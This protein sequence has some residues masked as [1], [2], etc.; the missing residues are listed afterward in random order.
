[1]GLLDGLLQQY[2]SA[3]PGQ[4]AP[5]AEDHFHEV[6]KALPADVIG[7]GVAEALRSDHTPP[8][9][10]MIGQLFGQSTPQQ[11]AGMLNQVLAALGP[12]ALAALGGGAL[13]GLV[14]PNAAAGGQ[15][16][17]Q[18]A[19]QLTP[20]QVERITAEA[21]KRNP[22]L[23]D[24]LGRFYAEHPGLVKT[25]GSAALTIVLA[26]VANHMKA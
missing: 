19:S 20:E 11:Q 23:V 12:T 18:Q 16:T 3:S 4:A 15:I 5:A 7:K 9:G 25:L 24:S 8:I 13:G 10:Q 6:S 14:S 17:P 22:S 1:M 21:A 2:L 26:K